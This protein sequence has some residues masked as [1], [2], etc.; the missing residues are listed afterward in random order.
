MS[1]RWRAVLVGLGKIGVGYADDPI[2]A[3]HSRFT[4]HAQV[5][6]GHPRFEWVG[7]VDIDE[8]ARARAA[9]RWPHV[10]VASRIDEL[11]L[12][13]PPHVLVL[14]N[15]PH[16]RIDIV[17]SVP[18]LRGLIVEKPIASGY[19]EAARFAAMC[20]A[21][22]LV[23]QINLWMRADRGLRD[24]RKNLERHVG[25]VRAIFGLYGNGLANNGTHLVDLMRCM[26]G[27]PSGAF[28]L[29][30]PRFDPGLPIDGDANLAFAVRWPYG[31]LAT[32]Q[33]IDYSAYRELALDV[34]G[35]AGRVSIQ[36]QGLVIQRYPIV[37]NRA[38]SDAREIAV[39]A[40]ERLMGASGDALLAMYDD[41]AESLDA[42][43]EPIS[44][45]ESALKT[46][47]LIAE[48]RGDADKRPSRSTQ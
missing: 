23:V 27:E 10:S 29:E 25:N 22:G 21:R 37:P 15:P 16:G 40:P 9:R 43:R 7:A 48:I 31:P 1:K 33:T 32:V 12:G 8:L 34:W 24:L 3:R 35:D 44:S 6:E 38:L 26:F 4:S 13:E 42:G 17:A 46:A 39:D 19:A 20:R 30:A 28:A 36:A 18:G 45:I 47:M 2:A 41:L 14:A 11:G 5:L